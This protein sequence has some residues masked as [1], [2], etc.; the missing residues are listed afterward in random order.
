MYYDYSC[1]KK[2]YEL[3]I[4]IG[5]DVKIKPTLF[6]S[7]LSFKYLHLL[8]IVNLSTNFVRHLR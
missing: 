2:L 6:K 7:N 5:I 3:L 4:S 8:Y 1:P